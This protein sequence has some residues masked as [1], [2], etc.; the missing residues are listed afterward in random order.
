MGMKIHQPVK[1]RKTNRVLGYLYRVVDG[2]TIQYISFASR[3]VSIS[4]DKIALATMEELEKEKDRQRAKGL[5][6]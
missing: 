6:G 2:R 1:M 5:R 3:V 4:S